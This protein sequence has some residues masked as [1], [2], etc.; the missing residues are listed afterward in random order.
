MSTI[1]KDISI[2]NEVLTLT[3]QR[4]LFW[5]QH[6]T[7][8]L[9]DL[10]IGKTAHFRKAGI[11]IPSAILDNDL[12]KLQDLINFFEAEIV[13]VVGDLFHAE[14]NTDIDQFQ[15]FL[16][17]NRKVSFELIKGNHDRLKN[18]FYESLGISVYKTHKDVAAFR[19]V[20][21]EQHCGEDIFC[22]SG[23]THPGVLI[24][25][26]GKVSIKLPCYELS[27]HRLI[28]P[29]FSEFTGL[30]TKRTV[31]SAIC[32]GFTEKSVFEI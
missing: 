23:H 11:P 31:D 12:K 16:Q 24:R 7:L 14:N 5:G 25:G 20:H 4:A 3:N 13:L 9:S 17:D 6:K 21:D 8:V 30:N 28:L 15:K 32:Y 10:H 27:E 26:R 19:F 18:S 2:Q 22:I 1:T 29:A